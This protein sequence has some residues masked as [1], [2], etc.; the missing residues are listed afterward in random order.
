MQQ[1]DVQDFERRQGRHERSGAGS[2]GKDDRE[3][4]GGGQYLHAALLSPKEEPA[5]LPLP[6]LDPIG[7]PLSPP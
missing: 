2:S 3:V 6:G 5:E 1:K 4:Q 7:L